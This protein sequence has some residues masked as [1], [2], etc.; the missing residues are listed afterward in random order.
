MKEKFMSPHTYS[1]DSL[2]SLLLL[3][4]RHPRAVLYA[5]GTL[6]LQSGAGGQEPLPQDLIYIGG[7]EE[8]KRINRTDRY[9]DISS[10]VSISSILETGR[11]VLPSAFRECL[12]G[13]ATPQ[14]R[15]LA[16]L[17]GNVCAGTQRMDAFPVLAL[18]EVRIEIRRAGSSRWL[19]LNRCLDGEG[20][21]ILNPGEA[22]T[23]LRIPYDDWNVQ[24]YKK[25]AVF[26]AFEEDRIIFCGLSKRQKNTLNEIRFIYC[27]GRQTLL[28]IRDVELELTGKSLPLSDRTIDQI[29]EEAKNYCRDIADMEKGRNRERVFSTLKLFL[30]TL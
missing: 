1:P 7:L 17:G 26:R 12:E 9:L 21:F 25:S 19:P 24:M 29:L 6:L 4:K 3:T 14:V 8:L 18:M 28:R 30:S 2:A 10:A 5:G 22:V 23:R 13:I 27:L 11:H 15:N 20:N 16:T